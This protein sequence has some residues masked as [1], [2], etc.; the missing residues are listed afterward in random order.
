M[1]A[2]EIGNRL[3]PVSSEPE[4][5]P[6]APILEERK[7]QPEFLESSGTIPALTIEEGEY[8]YDLTGLD[9]D[10]HLEQDQES[11]LESNIQKV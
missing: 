10:E 8:D 1:S 6:R 9:I 3:M 2:A 7:Q 4:L 5:N 11:L